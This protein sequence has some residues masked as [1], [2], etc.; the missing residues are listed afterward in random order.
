MASAYCAIVCRID[1]GQNADGGAAHVQLGSGSCGLSCC[2]LEFGLFLNGRMHG[3]FGD[4][5]GL[6]GV[7]QKQKWRRNCHKIRT[8]ALCLAR[9]ADPWIEPLA[10]WAAYFRG[11]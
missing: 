8:M 11:C 6:L 4:S 5:L 10:Q 1:R 3:Y 7:A 9:D 2:I